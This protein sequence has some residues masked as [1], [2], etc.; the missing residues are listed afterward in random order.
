M[1]DAGYR[2]PGI[3]SN[4]TSPEDMKNMIEKD[5]VILLVNEQDGSVG[6]SVNIVLN[7]KPEKYSDGRAYFG[8]LV[9]KDSL[10][11]MGYGKMLVK[12]VEDR[13]REHGAQTIM[14]MI[15]HPDPNHHE[16]KQ[17][18]FLFEWYAKLKYERSET[19]FVA[20]LYP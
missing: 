14:I 1:T 10:R 15:F 16:D 20:D 7:Y 3:E 17:K 18:T 4:R 2:K 5:E 9:V 6:G 8:M 11:G 12:A 13:A 19:I